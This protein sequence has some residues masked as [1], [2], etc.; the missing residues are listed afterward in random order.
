MKGEES[1]ARIITRGNL[2]GIIS[3]AVFLER[4]PGAEVTFVTSPPSAARA[5]RED[6]SSS[7]IYIADLALTDELAGAVR[8]VAGERTVILADHHPADETVD[9]AVIDEGRSAAGILHRCLGSSDLVKN[10]VALADMYEMSDTD[11]LEDVVQQYG[12]VRLEEECTVLDF[13]W[14]DNV[15]DD[16]F[17]LEAA[18]ALSKGALPSE[19]PFILERFMKVKEGG[20][21]NKAL[22]RVR[23]RLEKKG[24]VGVLDLRG[25]RTSLHGFGSKALLE[26]A[27]EQGCRYAVLI[28]GREGEAVVSLRAVDPHGVDLGKF[29]QEFARKHGTGGGG[30]PASAGARISRDAASLMISELERAAA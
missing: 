3:A 11:V 28:H 19:V 20:R 12:G 16:G 25:G 5:L 4:F 18:T 27:K 17:R 26:V 8:S 2:D 15:E 6:A 9:G 23:A 29:T 21:W 1:R 22:D 30:H 13:A 24:S 7:C 10:A 14:R